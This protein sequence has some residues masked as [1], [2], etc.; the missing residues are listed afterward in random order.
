[1]VQIKDEDIRIKPAKYHAPL[2]NHNS[3]E[4]L[5]KDNSLVNIGEFN[6]K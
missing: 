3:K 1:M 2:S 4:S 5:H 6:P